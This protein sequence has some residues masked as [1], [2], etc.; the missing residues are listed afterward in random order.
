[1]IPAFQDGQIGRGGSLAFV[2]NTNYLWTTSGGSVGGGGTVTLL[3]NNKTLRWAVPGSSGTSIYVRSVTAIAGPTYCEFAATVRGA[4]I[5]NGFG[6]QA[7]SIGQFFNNN[8]NG[9]SFFSGN[10][11]CGL[12]SAGFY[13]AASG[14]SNGA[15]S[16]AQGDRMG[17]A[18]DPSSRKF[19][20]SKN[21]VWISGDPAAGTSPTMTLAGGT[22]FYFTLG[23]YNCS[24][25][26][27][28][29]EWE[30]YP[31]AAV[32]LYAAP[33]GFTPYQV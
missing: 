2:P 20:V 24:V 31:A 19:W 32:Q 27:G 1:M 11:L 6:V 25:T 21:G 23:V 29:F 13:N 7:A 10:G 5:P 15:Y 30:I 12:A 16:F 18:F 26:S 9:G 14:S 4:S 28:T 3:N 33:T 17:I 8:A 22:T